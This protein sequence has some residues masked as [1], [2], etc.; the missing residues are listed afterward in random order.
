L[1]NTKKIKAR[2]FNNTLTI[3]GAPLDESKGV[4]ELWDTLREDYADWVAEVRLRDFGLGKP[5][6]ELLEWKGMSTWWINN[7]VR[8]ESDID[9]QWFRRMMVMYFCVKFAEDV[10]VETDDKI[11]IQSLKQNFPGIKV[12]FSSVSSKTLRELIKSRF[13]YVIRYLK[14][15]RSFYGSVNRWLLVSGMSSDK[16]ENFSDQVW[17]TTIFPANWIRSNDDG[18]YDRIL[19]DAPLQDRRYQLNAGYLVYIIRYSKDLKTSFFQ[20]R[21]ELKQLNKKTG[22]QISFPESRLKIKDIVGVYRS[23][24]QEWTHFRKW[25][26]EKRFRSLF[27]FAGIDF[28]AILMDHWE[29]SY[30]GLM[31]YCKLHGLSTMRFLETME[32]RQTIITTLELFVETRTDYHLVNLTKTK[33]VF[34]ALQHA[35]ESRN[36]GEAYN[37][38]SEFNQNRGRNYIHYCPMPDYFFVHGEQYRSIL[39]EFYPTNRIHIIGS[40]KVKQ[41]L[42]SISRKERADIQISSILSKENIINIV[43][44]LSTNDALFVFKILSEWKPKE[45]V[46]IWVTTHP[47]INQ[48]QIISWIDNYLSHLQVN[49]VTDISTWHLLPH[50]N[51]LVCGYSSLIYEALLFEIPTAVLQPVTIFP[52][53]EI[54]PAI[55][56]FYD[57]QLFDI[58]LNKTLSADS[59]MARDIDFEQLF[60]SYFYLP[61]GRAS[62]RMWNIISG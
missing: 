12:T 16:N 32:H 51:A 29:Q 62:E 39:A 20:L 25:K 31:Q 26:K 21:K 58:W 5:I 22:R 11:L 44:A 9:T 30:F 59:S 36:Y 13:P 53:R 6:V 8:K 27:T 41:Y 42:K 43:V 28:S 46:Q 55:P 40:I 37:R 61:D 18:Y 14:I 52:P 56:V 34:Y 57:A 1:D 35:Q 15:I 38:K 49:L 17:F 3:D 23:T 50:A 19:L 48:P 2:Y 4:R 60:I 7:L 45:N 54:D 47:V 24:I 10:D 33:A